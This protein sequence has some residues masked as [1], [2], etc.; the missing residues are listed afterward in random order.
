VAMDA[1][2]VV[3]PDHEKFRVQ[4]L[5]LCL[6]RDDLDF[7]VAN[8]PDATRNPSKPYVVQFD[9]KLRHRCARAPADSDG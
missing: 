1:T 4:V 5:Q 2:T 8:G 7:P 6:Q 3:M 9:T